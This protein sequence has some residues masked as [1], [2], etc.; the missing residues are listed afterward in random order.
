M[1]NNPSTTDVATSCKKVLDHMNDCIWSLKTLL[2]HIEKQTAP[3]SPDGYVPKPK[4]SVNYNDITSSDAKIRFYLKYLRERYADVYKEE[5]KYLDKKS[6]L[7]FGCLGAL[8]I[9][10]SDLQSRVYDVLMAMKYRRSKG[11]QAL[12][13]YTRAGLDANPQ[14]LIGLG[15]LKD[16]RMSRYIESK[17]TEKGVSSSKKEKS[18]ENSSVAE[19]NMLAEKGYKAMGV[20]AAELSPVDGLAESILHAQ[21][22]L[23]YKFCGT[24]SA[25]SSDLKKSAE[26]EQRKQDAARSK[27]AAARQAQVIAKSLA[28][29]PPIGL[30]TGLDV[31]YKLA[32]SNL[33]TSMDALSE[34]DSVKANGFTS[35]W[36]S[37]VDLY[38]GANST[39]VAIKAIEGLEN[40]SSQID[41]IT[42]STGNGFKNKEVNVS[43]AK[44]IMSVGNDFLSGIQATNNINS[45]VASVQEANVAG[46]SAA[47]MA[48]S[49]AS[50]A[51]TARAEEMRRN[52]LGRGSLVV[53]G[54]TL[55]SLLAKSA[56]DNAAAGM[57][58]YGSNASNMTGYVDAD[59]EQAKAA[60]AQK[61][62]A[63]SV[64]ASTQFGRTR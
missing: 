21:Y 53:A 47:D 3:P 54:S 7:D 28:A 19:N 32:V 16:Y 45:S 62:G 31:R 40:M 57:A 13:D 49:N 5:F 18:A 24:N 15:V 23:S 50:D 12:K 10:Q 43:S 1:A 55:D 30:D 14:V 35:D 48:V 61:N 29:A 51:Q 9:M 27:A 36:S 42:A 41:I 38:R 37:L 17:T 2:S 64:I 44:Y 22:P 56:T 8:D 6:L 26:E 60:L 46:Q 20:S 52:L 4:G 39:D 63:A 34:K 58:G 59:A 25:A 33:Q 11:I